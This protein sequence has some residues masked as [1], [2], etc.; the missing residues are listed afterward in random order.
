MTHHATTKA[1]KPL[2]FKKEFFPLV[3]ALRGLVGL[4]IERPPVVFA[5]L[6]LGN[7]PPTL[8]PKKGE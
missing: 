1:P 7:L 3:R 8:Y 5:M 4:A 2:A 6:A